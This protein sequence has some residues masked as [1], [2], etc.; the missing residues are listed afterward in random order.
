MCNL[1]DDVWEKGMKKGMEQGMEKG[2]KTERE[3][4][5]L[6]MNQKGYSLDQIADVV[7]IS[8]D[9]VKSVILKK[10]PAMA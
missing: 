7:G 3:K 5:I 8:A 4:F 6:S 2:A 10:E 9:D 1:S